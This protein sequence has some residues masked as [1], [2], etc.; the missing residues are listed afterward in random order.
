MS[1]TH[2]SL[3]A[4]V[5]KMCLLNK[6][7]PSIKYV[8]IADITTSPSSLIVTEDDVSPVIDALS[9]SRVIVATNVSLSV[10]SA[11]ENVESTVI[12]L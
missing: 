7:F 8:P 3:V 5:I 11:F 12:S 1:S 2:S 9:P 4:A 6:L 10:Y